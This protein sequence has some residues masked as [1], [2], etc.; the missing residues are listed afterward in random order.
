VIDLHC[1]ALPGID[2]GP[3][4]LEDAVALARAQERA[5]VRTVVA[6][7]HV[8]WDWP[9]NDSSRIAARV[10]DLNAALRDEGVDVEVLAG[11]EV[12]LTRAAE[13]D[14]DELRALRLGGGP[15]LL[16]EPPFGPAAAGGVALAVHAVAARGHRILL[17]H[18]ERCPAFLRDHRALEELFAGGVLC[19]ITASSLTGRFGREPRRLSLE[20]MRAGLVHDVASDA[21][22][23]SS[24]RGPGLAD[25]MEAAGFGDQVQ[26]YCDDA[27]RAILDGVPL[28]VRPPAPTQG[29]GGRALRRLLRRA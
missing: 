1:H 21:H 17:A 9:G 25:P 11:A 27:P 14:D 29:A 5:G 7:P 18:P 19:S 15:W 6:T 13:L 22:G 24:R 20:L 26:W 28:P 2:D 23:A 16:L 8:D 10:H 4:T 3:A 12:A